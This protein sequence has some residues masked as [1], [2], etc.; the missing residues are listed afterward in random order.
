[1]SFLGLI[2]R[3]FHYLD[4]S[5]LLRLYKAF[6]RPH[7]EYAQAVWSPSSA[8]LI[9]K[10]E[11]VQKRAL[12]L[13]PELRGLSYEEQLKCTRL[14][15]L[16]YRRFRGDL[17]EV[18]KHINQYDNAV[19][20]PS[21]V[22]TPRNR[23]RQ[24]SHKSALHARLFYFRVQEPWNALPASCRD[25]EISI[26]TFKNRVDKHWSSMYIPLLSDPL[27]GPPIRS[28]PSFLLFGAAR[29]GR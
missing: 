29:S 8:G 1:M 26:D 11:N 7:L 27:A 5:S 15:T 10:I 12:N 14:P 28:N 2:R 24:A 20:T 3:N 4:K 21:F 23:L 18:Y 6:V 17:I 16:A 22:A 25:P 19:T 9:T 13:V